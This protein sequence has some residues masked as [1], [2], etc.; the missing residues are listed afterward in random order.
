MAELNSALS[1]LGIN[2]I[3]TRRPSSDKKRHLVAA[4][5]SSLVPGAGQF[6]LG[7]TRSAAVLLAILLPLSVSIWPLRAPR[8]FGVFA[9]LAVLWLT[10][11]VYA[12]CS[13]L[14]MRARS[15]PVRPSRW[16]LA[17][18]IPLAL[19]SA[20]LVCGGLIRAAGFR[21][22][23]VP[24]TSMENTILRGERIVVDTRYYR[25]HLPGRGDVLV[26]H[27]DDLYVVKRIIALGGDTIEGSNRR[28]LLNGTVQKEP[29]IQHISEPGSS[30]DLDSFGPVVVPAGNYFV[31]G[32]NRDISLDSRYPG[33]GLVASKL[34][35]GK[36]LYTIGIF[37]KSD[38]TSIALEP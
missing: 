5:L 19:V 8:L 34:I 31:M 22:F 35:V 24:S 27:K 30:P 2:A 23:T 11:Y 17:V 7:E 20:H 15:T 21:A 33:Y 6:F 38:R 4:L 14:L 28:I 29:H 18:F 37:M 1:S 36:A 25:E 26:F 13:A 12:G 3:G 16:W 32:D 10:L 9:A